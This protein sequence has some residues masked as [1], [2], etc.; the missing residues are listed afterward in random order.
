MLRK[1]WDIHSIMRLISISGSGRSGS[2]FLSVLLTQN[3]DVFNLGQIRD[4]WRAYTQQAICSCGEPLSN[5][6]IWSTVVKQVFGASPQAGLQE[7][8]D[9]MMAFRKDA[10]SLLDWTDASALAMLASRHKNYLTRLEAFLKASQQ[11]SQS[12]TLL[13]FSKSP[14]IALACSLIK[15][16]EL[17]V[18][19]LVRDP[20]AVALS[21]EK[22][23]D[24][25]AAIRYTHVWVKRQQILNRMSTVLGKRFFS[26]RYEDLTRTP[27]PMIEKIL[28][29]AE[30]QPTAALFTSAQHAEVSWARQHLFPPANEKVLSE[31]RCSI[32]IMPSDEWRNPANQE[33]HR[34]VE[35]CVGDLLE[36]YGY[37]PFFNTAPSGENRLNNDKQYVFLICSERSGSNLISAILRCHSEIASPPPYHLCRDIGSNL[38]LTLG[39]DANAKILEKMKQLL[40]KRTTLIKS[41]EAAE[42]L[43]QWFNAHGNLD[44]PDFFRDLFYFMNEEMETSSTE[45]NSRIIFIK[46]NN[47]HE[48]LFF[49]LKYFPNAK[50]VFQ[51]RDPRDF[52]ASAKNRRKGWLGNKF[53]S[54]RNAMNTWREDQVGGLLALAHLGPDRVFFQ[55]YEDLVSDSGAVL[56]ALCRFL[57][58]DYEPAM[59]YFYKSDEAQHLAGTGGAR[60]NLD[61]PLIEGNFGK[62]RSTLSKNE[63]K[64]VEAYLG[65]LM[66]RFGY[67]RDYPETKKP[68]L[69]QVFWPQLM[70]PIERYFNGERQPYYSKALP[71]LVNSQYYQLKSY[72][73]Y[74]L[75][76]TSYGSA[77]ESQD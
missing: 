37:Q 57:H 25:D 42:R 18:L 6:V 41:P 51:V 26:L 48:R 10:E 49:L 60:E 19:N 17:H 33:M 63:I 46:E 1:T 3:V 5:C 14:E 73:Q 65:D 40:I 12:N 71:S 23:E 7:M 11:V 59:L 67:R 20:R 61:K 4:F 50:F 21:W 27:K 75:K 66:E 56:T 2:T 54:T 16:M 39:A 31:K 44:K 68:T 77:G 22:K 24:R 35:A 45:R 70:E 28:A 74:Q 53:S 64:V 58:I 15:N 69:F 52:M 9:W 8:H 34:L 62:Y 72:Q 38:H 29:W 13:E 36:R 43:T 30:L 47:I 76:T 55:R 32:D